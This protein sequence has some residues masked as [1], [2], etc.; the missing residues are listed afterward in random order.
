MAR[1]RGVSAATPRG[2]RSCPSAGRSSPTSRRPVSA[3][4]KIHRG[5]YGFLLESVQGGERWGR[6]SFLGT[7]PAMVLAGARRRCGSN[8]RATADGRRAHP[9]TDP[10]G[11]LER[12]PSGVATRGGAGSAALRG[13]RRRLPRVR[14]RARASSGY[15]RT[16]PPTST[17]PDACLL[18][19]TNLLVFDNVAQTI[20]AV[21][22]APVGAGIDPDRAYDDAVRRLDE[23]VARLRAPATPPP[24][25]AGRPRPRDEQRVARRVPGGS[26]PREG[27]HLRRRRDPGGAL[28]A[29]RAA[30]A[31]RAHQRLPVS[32]HAQPV[33]LHVLPRAGATCRRRARRP[34]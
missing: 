22:N 28:A 33:T 23:L 5:R 8:A 17:V 20:T 9:T 34:K 21:V 6:Y 31:G 7:E 3:F 27:V 32:A 30:A 14:R 10:M 12:D 4:L 26:E 18:L 16:S 15:R 29:L 1:A 2:R 19:A 11:E 25:R 13:R 24:G